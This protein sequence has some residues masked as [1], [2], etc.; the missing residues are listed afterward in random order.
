MQWNFETHKHT[1]YYEQINISQE[2]KISNIHSIIDINKMDNIFHIQ[3]FKNKDDKI[4]IP[5][6]STVIIG[7]I[8]AYSK[9]ILECKQVVK[10][11]KKALNFQ[12]KS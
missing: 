9:N 8:F 6:N 7:Y 2:G 3:L 11:A 4:I 1:S 12:I 5:K 10:N